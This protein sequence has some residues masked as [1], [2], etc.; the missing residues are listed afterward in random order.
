MASSAAL[1]SGLS[2]ISKTQARTLAHS[3]RL[4]SI[5]LWCVTL[6]HVTR[7]YAH[8]H[9]HSHRHCMLA[10]THTCVLPLVHT[11]IHLCTHTL[12]QS[13]HL[14]ICPHIC[15]LVHTYPHMYMLI[16]TCTFSHIYMLL[17]T[18]TNG[19]TAIAPITMPL[20]R[21]FCSQLRGTQ[22][23]LCWGQQSPFAPEAA[24]VPLSAE[25]V[26]TLS[27]RADFSGPRSVQ[28]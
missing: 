7:A 22:E 21:A 5:H 2:H 18:C 8:T 19:H 6:A 4:L 17:C 13:S 16:L 10:H 20:V 1:P 23:R 11:L 14:F 25:Q 27:N 24:K 28:L 12:I 3:T 15:T 9:M 26:Q